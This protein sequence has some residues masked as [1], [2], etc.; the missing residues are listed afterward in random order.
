M[1]VGSD[2]PGLL[3]NSLKQISTA[4][5]AVAFYPGQHPAVVSA[6]GRASVALKEA[7]AGRDEVRLGVLETGFVLADE[8]V[9]PEDPALAGF[10]AYL[11]RRGVGVIRFRPP[12]QDEALRGL[13]E[14][15]ALDPGA[16]RSRGGPGSCL[17]ERK[18]EGA[19]IDDLDLA[20]IM[21]TAR[22]EG[23]AQPGPQGKS[24]PASWS[25]LLS[26]F[27]LG[28]EENCPSG[29]EHLLRRVA[30]D[31]G[32]AK[33]LMA[34]LQAAS[35]DRGNRGPLLASALQQVASTVAA[36][37]PEALATLMAHLAAAMSELDVQGRLEV[38]Q[39]SIP[40]SGTGLD[41]AR[42]VRARIPDE[43]IADLVVSLVQAEGSVNARLGTVIRKVLSDRG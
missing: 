1:A 22:T 40:V 3:A 24:A 29:G 21:R 4:T 30:G 31:A 12:V 6:I 9:A 26:R 18:V 16:L 35:K 17:R 20:A 14:V 39:A 19:S 11:S 13:L 42:E 36:A 41:L 2:L 33:E 8:P 38:L 43:A 10:A 5:K 34:S 28:E 15:I 27:L 7:L 37:E 32:A 25:D 23:A